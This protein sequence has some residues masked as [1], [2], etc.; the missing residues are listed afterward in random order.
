MRDMGAAISR[1]FYYYM[2]QEHYAGIRECFQ[3][4]D[5]RPVEYVAN[6]CGD[7]MPHWAIKPTPKD[8]IG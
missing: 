3:C 4:G 6:D 8:A 7:A 2:V 5:S 1:E